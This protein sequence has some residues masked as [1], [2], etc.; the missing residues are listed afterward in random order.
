MRDA[1]HFLQA[2]DLA[3][4]LV[5]RADAQIAVE[6]FVDTRLAFG[7]DGHGLAVFD[8]LI[9]VTQAHRHAHVPARVLGRV[10]RIGVV[11]R[12]VNRALHAD[13]RLHFGLYLGADFVEH[14]AE[15]GKVLEGDAKAAGEHVKAASHCRL[16]RVRALRDDPHGRMRLLLRLREHHGF[17]NLVMRTGIAEGL[18]F[19]GF[20]YNVECFVV[21]LARFVE[22]EAEARKLVL[23]ITAAEADVGAPAGQQIKRG[24]FL[25]HQ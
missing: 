6:Q 16:Y 2:L 20:E 19:E 24:D 3:Y 23:L 14:F 5:G 13:A 8:L 1:H 11:L 12:D 17:G 22:I 4:A 9:A 15:S 7:D 25:G 10:A 21:T 18:A